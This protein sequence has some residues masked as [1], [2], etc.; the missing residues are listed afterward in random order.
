VLKKHSSRHGDPGDAGKIVD[1]GM[2]G[3]GFESEADLAEHV[4][5]HLAEMKLNVC[6][7]CGRRLAPLSS[8]EKHLRTH[9][10]AKMATCPVCAREFAEV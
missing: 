10:G 4:I 2:C 8:M 6:L 9:T 1:C 7:V 5:T 3:N